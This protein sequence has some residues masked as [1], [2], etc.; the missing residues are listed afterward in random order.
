MAKPFAAFLAEQRQGA[1]LAE[2][3]DSLAE[4]ALAATEV[5][6]AGEVTL[7][8][9]VR[10]GRAGTLE[11]TDSVKAKLPEADRPAALWWADDDGTLSDRD[12]RQPRL[13]G[14]VTE[15]PPLADEPDGKSKAAGE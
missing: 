15:V 7:T 6:K 2:L 10:P 4:V 5:G 14:T 3:T 12:P 1:L 11:I 13:P 9:K 8:V